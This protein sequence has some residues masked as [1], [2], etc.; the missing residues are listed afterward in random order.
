MTTQRA[1]RVLIAA[2]LC[3]CLVPALLAQRDMGT[4]LG[5]VADP[6]GAVVAGAKVIITEDATKLSVEL[7]TDSSGNYIRPLLKPGVYTVEV[8]MAGFEKRYRRT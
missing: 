1:R 2:V 5:V 7:T 6:T 3:L 8:E 4:I